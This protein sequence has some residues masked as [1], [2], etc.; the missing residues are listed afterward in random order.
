MS[1]DSFCAVVVLDHFNG[2]LKGRL[3][4]CLE[5]LRVLST[6]LLAHNTGEKETHVNLLSNIEEEAGAI[7]SCELGLDF[8]K[9]KV[10]F[11]AGLEE[12]FVKEEGLVELE[13]SSKRTKRI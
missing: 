8:L 2:E 9:G 10:V 1:C 5:D 13:M 12:E 6:V 11:T 3:G 4:R 7:V